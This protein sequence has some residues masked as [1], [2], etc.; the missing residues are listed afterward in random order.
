MLREPLLHFL[1]CAA[2]LLGFSDFFWPEQSDKVVR[3]SPAMLDQYARV[4]L[5]RSY[6]DLSPA[7]RQKLADDYFTE[8]VLYRE[9]KA[10]GLDDKDPA[11]RLRLADQMARF[12]EQLVEFSAP[13]EGEIE[14]YFKAHHD[15]FVQP[16]H[17]SFKHLYYGGA[18]AR[19]R[20]ET[21]RQQLQLD[22]NADPAADRFLYLGSYAE[23]TAAILTSHFGA[24]FTSAVMSLSAPENSWLGPIQ[25][26]HGYHLVWIQKYSAAATPTLAEVAGPVVNAIMRERRDALRQK[27][28]NKL[29]GD[30]RLEMVD[31]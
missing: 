14:A 27:T 13:T 8:E 25:S 19:Q 12:S 7:A 4:Q 20:A 2:L 30:Y 16:A 23:R 29:K 21:A 1:V 10:L 3:V 18:D 5:Q 9:A 15:E 11:I 22:V 28:I 24:A 26:E 17:V 31:S 6:A